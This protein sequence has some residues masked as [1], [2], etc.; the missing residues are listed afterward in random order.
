MLLDRAKPLLGAV[1]FLL[2]LC[3][4]LAKKS[5]RWTYPRPQWPVPGHR[6]NPEPCRLFVWNAVSAGR[7]CECSR[8]VESAAKKT[9]WK[10]SHGQLWLRMP[11]SSP[12]LKLFPCQQHSLSRCAKCG[13]DYRAHVENTIRKRKDQPYDK[14]VR[15]FQ[16]AAERKSRRKGGDA[17]A[18]QDFRGASV[19]S[20]KRKPRRDPARRD[21]ARR[22]SFGGLR[23][24]GSNSDIPTPNGETA[25][26]AAAATASD[27]SS[28]TGRQSRGDSSSSKSNAP[29]GSGGG[30]GGNLGNSVAWRRR[31]AVLAE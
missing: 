23:R 11:A 15:L 2:S 27:G 17:A 7:F 6:M 28:P 19:F 31:L 22:A 24:W 21:P 9:L 3:T 25:T 13:H 8:L 26:A 18:I 20:D 1:L 14:A 12:L 30:G 5:K 10:D 4:G 29:S 16:E